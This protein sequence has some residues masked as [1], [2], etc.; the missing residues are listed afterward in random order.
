MTM[1]SPGMK[2]GQE[3]TID[4]MI[5]W[6]TVTAL[7]DV[8]Y[9]QP[10]IVNMQVYHSLQSFVKYYTNDTAPQPQ[11]LGYNEPT[12]QTNWCSSSDLPYPPNEPDRSFS[13]GMLPATFQVLTPN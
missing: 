2:N 5:A 10:S 3:V 7:T 11:Q 6:W 4:D 1:A 9:L 13:I 12:T 8:M